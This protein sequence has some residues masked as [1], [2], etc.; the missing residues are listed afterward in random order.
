MLTA[1]DRAII[2]RMG[3][4]VVIQTDDGVREAKV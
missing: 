1:P 3:C 2:G 4:G